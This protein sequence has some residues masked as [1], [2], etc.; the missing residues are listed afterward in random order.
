MF[1][2]K[3]QINQEAKPYMLSSLY[4]KYQE[5]NR[6]PFSKQSEMADQINKHNR[7]FEQ[8]QCSPNLQQTYDQILQAYVLPMLTDESQ[9][10]DLTKK[11]IQHLGIKDV[12]DKIM[13]HTQQ[14]SLT[15][16]FSLRYEVKMLKA[17]LYNQVSLLEKKRKKT[18]FLQNDFLR[19]KNV[20]QLFV[21]QSAL[22][23]TNVVQDAPLSIKLY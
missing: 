19:F 3:K 11:L 5:N 14:Y 23:S 7:P 8:T 16:V 20:D 6:I 15:P 21:Q 9:R 12:H 17:L 1:K 18:E 10:E 13:E 22:I 4:Y 2:A